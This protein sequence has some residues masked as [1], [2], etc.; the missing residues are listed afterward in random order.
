MTT[1]QVTVNPVVNAITVELDQPTVTV[2]T[3]V[4]TATGA[5]GGDLAGNYPSPTVDG[6]QG[7][8]VASTAPSNGQAL[9]W[10]ASLAQW[11]PTTIT[12]SISD[13]DKGDITVSASGATWTIDSGAVTDTKIASG[14]VTETKIAS[15][16]VSTTKI[17]TDGVESVNIKNDAVTQTKIATSAVTNSKIAAKAVTADKIADNTI[18][19]AQVANNTITTAQIAQ[20][21]Q[22]TILGRGS[23]GTGNIENIGLTADFGI[24]PATLE[25]YLTNRTGSSIIG[26]SASSAGAPADITASADGQVLRRASGT[27]G[28]GSI[29]VTSVTNASSRSFAIAMAV[30]L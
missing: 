6:L 25:L 24:D 10:N 14:A 12:V 11:E 28:F 22:Q 18:T 21:P 20:V 13:G 5:A 4:S 27:V 15:G 7:R 26:R 23:I 1:Y 29:S 30:A 3:T 19:A 8:S 2:S 17:A 16:A 9:A